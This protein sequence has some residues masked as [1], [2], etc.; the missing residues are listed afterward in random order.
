IAFAFGFSAESKGF[1]EAIETA[2]SLGKRRPKFLLIVSGAIHPLVEEH[3]TKILRRMKALGNKNTMILG[4]YLT[5]KEINLYASACDVLVFNYLTPSYVSSASGA[6]KRVLAAG[7]PII[8]PHDNRLEDLVEGQHCLKYQP[9]DPLDFEHTLELVLTDKEIATKLGENC[10]LLAEQTSWDNIAK[11]HIE[12]YGSIVGEIFD[13]KWYDKAY[14]DVGED[15]P[16][17]IYRKEDGTAGRWGYCS[18][19]LYNW[20]AWINIV[21]GLKKI[22]QPKRVLDVGCGC[23]G[24]V[25]YARKAGLEAWGTDFSDYAAT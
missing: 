1:I 17:K 5:E 15:E 3:C 7:K 13:Q 22:F 10:R 23:N 18:S 14:F 4:R 6:L 25:Y 21:V 24:F 8:G 20:N 19:S 9:S 16:G 2:V 12:L 11:K